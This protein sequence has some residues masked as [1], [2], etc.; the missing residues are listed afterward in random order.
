MTGTNKKSSRT[1]LSVID[2]FKRFYEKYA[3]DAV[4]DASAANHWKEKVLYLFILVAI[5]VGLV[6]LI[7]GIPGNIANEYWLIQGICAAGYLSCL[8]IFLFPKSRFEYRASIACGFIYGIGMS[9]I[10]TVGPFLASREW[11]FSFSIIA[12]ILLGWPGAIASIIIN[13]MTWVIVGVLIQHGYWDNIFKLDDALLYWHMIAIDLLFINISTTILIT[14][15]FIRLDQSD[16]SAKTFSQLLLSERNKLSESNQK[17]A[18]EIEERKGIT[19][20]LRESEEKYRTILETIEDAYFEVDMQGNLTFF[21]RA[22]CQRL[23]FS[24]AELTG[25]SYRAYTDK[26]NAEKL[27]QVFNKVFTTGKSS[28]PVDL[29]V[30][31]KS[32]GIRTVSI[33]TSLICNNEGEAIGFQGL[34]RDITEHKMMES[35]LRRAQ[36]MEAVGTLA[37]GV[38]HD[39]NNTLSGVVSYPELLLMKM[40][41]ADPMRKPI[42][43]IKKSGERAVAIVQDLLTLARR[44]VAV[45]EVT[46]L[47]TI[48]TEYLQST[49]FQTLQNF[50][51]GVEVKTHLDPFLLNLSG[52]PVHLTKTVMNLVSNAAEA[53]KE[54]GLITITTENKWVE[55]K[56]VQEENMPSGDCVVFSII[57]TGGGIAPGDIDKIFEPFFTKKVMGRSGTGLGMAVVWGTVQDHGGHIDVKSTAGQGTTFTIYFPATREALPAEE[58]TLSID[59]FKGSGENVLIVDDVE[60]QREIATAMLITL[61]YTP[62]AVKSGEEA[63]EYLKTR[64]VEL[65]LLDMI[66]RPGID[67]LETYKRILALHPGQKAII[68]SGFSE[69]E[70]VK[71]A[72]ALG[73]GTY[74][75]KPYS[76]ER[77]GL[78]IRKE[79]M[80]N[81]QGPRLAASGG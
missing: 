79:L 8:L 44:G 33:L 45:K 46:N 14:L 47:N 75:R 24:E 59:N 73:A 29:E 41:D 80:K 70:R 25:M 31:S 32:K 49:E 11:L 17:L 36:K 5:S 19:R 28:L 1:L 72:Q 35:R 34:A 26:Q 37:G 2:L 3:P 55:T 13:L 21:N 53:I 42:A 56:T 69:T 16:R 81:Q 39:L 27:Y 66:M 54:N 67:G 51:P 48:I 4:L 76:I 58:P 15:F 40:K 12:S 50:H 71:E 68:A 61:G 22:L 65:V 74:I 9:V 63:V 62:A 78:A 23:G 18:Q 20:A 52:S 38:A 10:L 57:D 60:T 6:I 77:L 43:A 7:L 30:I 64:T